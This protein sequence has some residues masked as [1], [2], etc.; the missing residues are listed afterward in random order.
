MTSLDR[1]LRALLGAFLEQT[2][3]SARRFGVEALGDPGFMVLS[4]RLFDH[5]FPGLFRATGVQISRIV[6][7]VR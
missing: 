6:R 1:Q 4:R 2:D 5:G 3:T 7:S